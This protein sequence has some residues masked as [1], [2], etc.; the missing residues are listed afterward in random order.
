MYVRLKHALSAVALAALRDP[1]R[2]LR[3]GPVPW[4]RAFCTLVEQGTGRYEAPLT[5]VAR[6]ARA[7]RGRRR[8]TGTVPGQARGIL[9][10][11]DGIVSLAPA[12]RPH[13][14]YLTRQVRRLDRALRTL[15]RHPAPPG[16]RGIVRRGAALFNAGLFFECHEYLEPA[17]RRASGADRSFYHGIIL[18]A[19]AFY[20]HEKGNLHGARIKLTEG[21]KALQRA[22][23]WSDLKVR[24]WLQALAPWRSRLEA[25]YIPG[26]LRDVERP[27]MAFSREQRP[28]AEGK[29]VT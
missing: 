17:W 26:V 20:H 12:Y 9:E 23:T 18:V 25:G 11:A 1:A 10:R 16:R 3:A 7:F 4:L 29:R 13:A 14:G 15:A 6:L 24:E 27:R 2:S 5:E 8:N 21:M 28:R 22:P 19:A